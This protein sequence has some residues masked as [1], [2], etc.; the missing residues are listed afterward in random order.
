MNADNKGF[1]LIELV[2]ALA[3]SGIVLVGLSVLVTQ[4]AR[5]YKN[6]S[7]DARIQ[8]S[9]D[10]SFSI[11]EK[12]ILNATGIQIYIENGEYNLRVNTTSELLGIRYD[13]DNK[14]LIYIDG[15]DESFIADNV[16]LCEFKLNKDCIKQTLDDDGR[17]TINDLSEK[18]MVDVK[19]GIEINGQKREL[20]KSFTT[21]NKS[22]D[23]LY[24]GMENNDGVLSFV[25]INKTDTEVTRI[26]KDMRDAFIKW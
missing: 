2:I 20:T 16:Y 17:V 3:V 19:I 18:I 11:I 7:I 1:S 26:S 12:E 4:S 5:N 23:S 13:K 22:S 8:T 6:E 10:N 21:R 15:S 24:L 14:S 9:L 25:K